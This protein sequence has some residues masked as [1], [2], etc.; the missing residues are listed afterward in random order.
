MSDQITAE[1]INFVDS[2]RLGLLGCKNEAEVETV[3]S[4]FKIENFAV[5]T[6]FLHRAMQMETYGISDADAASNDQAVYKYYLK[7]YLDGKWKDFI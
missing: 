2:V 6:E 4:K 3:F 1:N 7:I 5:K